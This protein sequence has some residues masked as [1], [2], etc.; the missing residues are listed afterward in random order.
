MCFLGRASCSASGLGHIPG[1]LTCGGVP[2]LLCCR[3]V[4]DRLGVVTCRCVWGDLPAPLMFVDCMLVALEMLR[5]R[6]AE[7]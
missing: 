1:I 3:G 5:D 2:G 4:V 7:L 6:D